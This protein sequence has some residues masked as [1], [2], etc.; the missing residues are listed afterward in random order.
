MSTQLSPQ[1]AEAPEPLTDTAKKSMEHNSPTHPQRVRTP[2]PA[3]LSVPSA[4]P[5]IPSTF[6]EALDHSLTQW[7]AQITRAYSQGAA[8]E[9]AEQ[10]QLVVQLNDSLQQREASLQQREARLDSQ[11][12]ALKQASEDT[13]QQQAHTQKQR[14]AIAQ[15][16]RAQK[17]EWLLERELLR[18]SEEEQSQLKRMQPVDSFGPDEPL[19]TNDSSHLREELQ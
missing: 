5:K 7:Q 10:L 2:T 11:R 16:M 19:E 4:A 1:R 12:L 3:R 15:L 9:I 14:R 6:G 17:A 13:L 18:K 8:Q